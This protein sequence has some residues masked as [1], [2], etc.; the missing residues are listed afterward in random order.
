MSCPQI[1]EDKS[2]LGFK[3]GAEHTSSSHFSLSPLCLYRSLLIHFNESTVFAHKWLLPPKEVCF[4]TLK[5]LV[6]PL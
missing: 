6:T 2:L 5:S 1:I 3:I 4:A